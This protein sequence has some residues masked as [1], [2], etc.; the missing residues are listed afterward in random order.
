[1]FTDVRCTDVTNGFRV[2]RLKIFS[3]ERIDIWQDWFDEY[4]LEYG[5]HYKVLALGYKARE[6]PVSKVYPYSHKGGYSKI[7]PFQD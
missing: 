4:G 3:D 2:Y 6:V 1:M 7:S 5:V